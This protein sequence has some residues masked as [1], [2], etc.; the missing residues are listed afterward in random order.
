MKGPSGGVN[1]VVLVRK[2]EKFMGKLSSHSGVIATHYYPSVTITLIWGSI[3]STLPFSPQC[4]SIISWP[5]SLFMA[6]PL[7]TSLVLVLL[8]P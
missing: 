7:H 1:K 4:Y 6:P 5:P 3:P 8:P 2:E